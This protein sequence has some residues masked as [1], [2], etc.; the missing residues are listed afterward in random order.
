MS[1][2]L[3]HYTHGALCTIIY[4]HQT[5]GGGYMEQQFT[6]QEL[7]QL[8]SFANKAMHKLELELRKIRRNRRLIQQKY[9]DTPKELI[10]DDGIMSPDEQIESIKQD[11]QSA[12]TL[13][14]KI[15]RNISQTRTLIAHGKVKE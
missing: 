2:D 12:K 8:E 7:R 4:S 3:F 10:I 14:L 5:K 9:D 13:K 1:I 11:K 15:Q 6:L